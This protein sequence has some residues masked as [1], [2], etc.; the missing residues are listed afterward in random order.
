[1]NIKNNQQQGLYLALGCYSIWGLFPLYWAPL[2]HDHAAI[3]A[4]QVLAQRIIWSALFSIILLFLF[5]RSRPVMQALTQPKI[6]V[7]FFISASLIGINWFVYLWALINHH[8]LDASLGYLINPLVNILLGTL[9][10][11][12]SSTLTQ[13]IAILL[14]GI[15]I[16]WLAIPIG[17][18]PWVALLLSLSFGGYGLMRKIA[19]IDALSGLVLET[20]FLLPIAAGYLWWCATQH[21]LVFTQL[22]PLQT[23]VLIGSGV[24]TT[25]PLLMFA[26]AA[27]RISLSLL[28]ILQYGSP[29]LHILLGL[30]LFHEQLSQQEWIAYTWVWLGVILFLWD[31]YKRVQR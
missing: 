19:P 22:T 29:S 16:L 10:F 21:Q 13:K 3:P 26:G 9:F 11:R 25:I 30:F 5:K 2:N 24:A 1:M 23:F 31:A 20:L 6:V 15:G 8:I 7:T 18:I 27:K 28:G 17:S 14:A 12:E 4:Q